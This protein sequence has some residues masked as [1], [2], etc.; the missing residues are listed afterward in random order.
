MPTDD[1][2]LM[3]VRTVTD[4]VSSVSYARELFA[5]M[6]VD[7]SSADVP[8]QHTQPDAVTAASTDKVEVPTTTTTTTTSSTAEMFIVA[9][10]GG[11][12]IPQ[13]TSATSGGASDA[14]NVFGSHKV[15]DSKKKSSPSV[16][17][18]DNGDELSD[19]VQELQQQRMLLSPTEDLDEVGL[20]DDV[21]LEEVPL[22]PAT[23][24]QDA[25]NEVR[26]NNNPTQTTTSAASMFSSIGLPPPPFSS[27]Q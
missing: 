3:M 7:E 5:T 22:T 24:E 16:S 1:P 8:I 10:T 15:D 4:D 26:N 6:C 11:T 27:R 13:A 2:A 19:N 17:V 9:P 23:M 21:P 14:E 12:S 20:D 25:N 18:T